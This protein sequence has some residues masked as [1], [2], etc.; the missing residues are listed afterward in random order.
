MFTL[1]ERVELVLLP[2]QSRTFKF[3]PA[4]FKDTGDSKIILTM[5]YFSDNLDL[6]SDESHYS[7][8]F[9]YLGSCL[10]K[11]GQENVEGERWDRR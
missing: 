10:K 3:F 2:D 11:H 8:F 5:H 9:Y 6:Q 7:D 4:F 1:N